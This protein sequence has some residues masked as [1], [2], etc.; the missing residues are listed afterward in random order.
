MI[1]FTLEL[2]TCLLIAAFSG[3]AALMVYFAACFIFKQIQR[4]LTGGDKEYPF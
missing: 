1:L 3:L 4:V 2:C